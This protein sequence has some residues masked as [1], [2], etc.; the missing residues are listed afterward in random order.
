MYLEILAPPPRHPR[1]S[2]ANYAFTL[3]SARRSAALNLILHISSIT[4]R[5]LGF[6]YRLRRPARIRA[7]RR[8]IALHLMSSPPT[9]LLNFDLGFS[10]QTN[11][12]VL[13]TPT[14][15]FISHHPSNPNLTLADIA[16]Y[17]PDGDAVPPLVPPLESRLVLCPEASGSWCY[18]HV[19]HGDVT[20]HIPPNLLPSSSPLA[21]SSA[22][23]PSLTAFIADKPPPNLDPRLTLDTMER[24]TP[25]LPL[26]SDHNNTITFYNKYTGCTRLAPWLTLRHC[27]RV[28]FAN[29]ITGETRWAPPLRW[30]SDWISRSSSFSSRSPYTRSLLPPSLARLHVEG[31]APYLDSCG[32]PRYESDSSDSSDTYPM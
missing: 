26:Y 8:S 20:W 18:Y 7:T 9:P 30:L 11:D 23:L 27:G 32:V 1:Q 24:N 14:G 31:G 29:I 13:R 6:I 4:W 16:A 28:Y 2:A 25:W 5:L 17:S 21:S 19:D 10:D 12:L 3:R 22:A 15:N